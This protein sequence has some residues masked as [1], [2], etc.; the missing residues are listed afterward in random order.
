MIA[1]VYIDHVVPAITDPMGKHWTQPERAEI[2]IDDTFAVMG[3]AAFDRLGEYSCSM[4]TGT[5]EGKMWKA[6]NCYDRTRDR[7]KPLRWRLC[8]FGRHDDPTKLSIHRRE[9]IV[10]EVQP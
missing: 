1:E 6:S 7:S 2:G 4:P 5:Y 9:I 8:W 3:Q 10:W